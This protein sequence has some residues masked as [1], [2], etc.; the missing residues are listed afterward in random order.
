MGRRPP[1]FVLNTA[2]A[3]HLN[4]AHGLYPREPLT[5][6]QLEALVA[7]LNSSVS[8]ADGRTYAGG[9]VKFEPKEL[10]RLRIP[11]LAELHESAEAVDNR[12]TES[13]RGHRAGEVSRRAAR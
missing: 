8:T 2:G 7:H 12:A 4:I 3:R 1:V 13:R 5:R 11:R 10:E 9:L 6:A